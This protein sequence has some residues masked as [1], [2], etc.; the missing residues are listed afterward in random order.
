MMNMLRA[1]SKNRSIEDIV[2]KSAGDDISYM[3]IFGI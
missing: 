2:R 3:V 1:Y